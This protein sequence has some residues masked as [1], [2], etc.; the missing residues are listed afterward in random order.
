MMLEID[1]NGRTRTVSLERVAPE[2]GQFRVT[3]DDR[4]H[5]VD[6][7]SV[8]AST[9]SLILLDAGGG[10][11][12]VGLIESGVPGE[13]IAWTSEGPVHVVVN[14]RR[15][16]RV[17]AESSVELSGER[18]VVAPMPGKVVR[19]LVTPGTEVTAGQGLAVVEAMKMENAVTSPKAGRVKEVAVEE[20]MSVETGRL[21]VVVE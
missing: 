6:A 2:G 18:R 21:L 12:E 8:D 5:V 16:R 11:H 17:G 7:C 15:S 20:G 14:G 19:V 4:V 13:L 1:V 10:S 3:I 9:L